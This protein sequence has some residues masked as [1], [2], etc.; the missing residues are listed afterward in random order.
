MCAADLQAR[1]TRQCLAGPAAASSMQ[2][3]A[4]IA[5][6]RNGHAD[7]PLAIAQRQPIYGVPAA[8][9][10][11]AGCRGRCILNDRAPGAHQQLPPALAPCLH[12]AGYDGLGALHLRRDA[13]EGLEGV[14]HCLY[15]ARGH[16]K[17]SGRLMRGSARQMSGVARF[18][19][20]SA[21]GRQSRRAN[22][23]MWIYGQ[24]EGRGARAV[25]AQV[26]LE[27]ARESAGSGSSWARGRSSEGHVAVFGAAE[28]Y[29]AA[30]N[31]AKFAKPQFCADRTRTHDALTEGRGGGFCR[32]N[33]RRSAERGHRGRKFRS[34]PRE[35][36]PPRVSPCL[37]IARWMGGVPRLQPPHRSSLPPPNR[38]P[39]APL[40]CGHT[41]L[42]RHTD[43]R[44][45][46]GSLTR[47]PPPVGAKRPCSQP[48]TR[49]LAATGCCWPM[50]VGPTN[51]SVT[52]TSMS[53]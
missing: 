18:L 39:P 29:S 51:T 31:V 24:L 46:P 21:L 49:R 15:I 14:M 27:G 33:R 41:S 30:G 2:A 8:L 17:P 48:I 4:A 52:R 34:P 10:A 53:R 13:L 23:N 6:T 40:R 25:R 42:V 9:P 1:E 32:G 50:A 45:W 43:S 26:V 16:Q 19:M 28:M 12:D 22:L 36:P 44:R 20:G 5:G 47:S 37:F 35:S 11:S 7:A 38:C 3:R